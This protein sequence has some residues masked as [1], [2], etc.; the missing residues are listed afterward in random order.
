MA[1]SFQEPLIHRFWGAL[2][3]G[4]SVEQPKLAVRAQ[5]EV[6]RPQILDHE[7]G[8]RILAGFDALSDPELLSTG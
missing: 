5:Y 7:D 2:V 8:A 1:A 6:L 3:Q 4:A